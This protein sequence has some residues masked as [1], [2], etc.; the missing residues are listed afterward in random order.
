[1]SVL[2]ETRRHLSTNLSKSLQILTRIRIKKEKKLVKLKSILP[3]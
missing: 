2:H 3:I 1:M